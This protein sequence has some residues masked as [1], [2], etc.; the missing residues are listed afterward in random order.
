MQYHTFPVE[1]DSSNTSVCWALNKPQTLV[2]F[3]HGFNGSAMKTWDQFPQSFNQHPEFHRCD[4]VFWGYD[5]L[6]AQA[7]ASAGLF[8]NFL[9]KII[10]YPG[11]AM[12]TEHRIILN[13]ELSFSYDRIV[14]VAHSL[15]SIIARRALLDAH[16]KNQTWLDKT[17][18]VLF[19]PA[20]NGALVGRLILEALTGNFRLLSVVARFFSPIIEDLKPESITLQDIRDETDALIKA[21]KGGFT[22][23]RAVIWAEKDRIIQMRRFGHDPVAVVIKNQTHTSVCKPKFNTG[24][25]QPIE[26]VLDVLRHKS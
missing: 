6:F 25:T 13:R 2:V 12:E 21:G 14:I 10:N 4:F 9:H 8:M 7:T 15:G 17:E 18:M 5:S 22:K 16:Y 1:I 11:H 26:V 23:S 24:F 19:A 3:V 20:H